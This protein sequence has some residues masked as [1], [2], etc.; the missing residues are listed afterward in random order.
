MIARIGCLLIGHACPYC[1]DGPGDRSACTNCHEPCPACGWRPKRSS[2]I[3]VGANLGRKAR[4][5]R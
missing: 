2:G 1:C 4:P 3:P 5:S